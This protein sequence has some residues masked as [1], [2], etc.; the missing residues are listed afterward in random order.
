MTP[1]DI[2]RVQTYLRRLLGSDKIRINPPA[3][4][5]LSVEI[6][7]EDEVIAT[8]TRARSPTPS[9]SSCWKKTCRRPPRP[10]LPNLPVVKT[11]FR[12][13]RLPEQSLLR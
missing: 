11:N 4:K 10:L 9:R 12:V 1:T 7:V 2:A 5:G 6:A 8:K 3:K 13:G